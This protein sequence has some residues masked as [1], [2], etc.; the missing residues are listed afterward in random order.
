MS[1]VEKKP[2]V[3]VW[4]LETVPDL[5]AVARVHGL[6]KTE[7]GE[8]RKTL[9]NKFPRLLFHEI[10]CVGALVAE[11]KEGT[12]R[13]CRVETPHAG[14]RTE[15]ELIVG[16]GHLIE[17]FRPR[18]VSYNGSSFDMPVMRYRALI[19]RV[20]MPALARRAYFHRYGDAALDL[21][22]VLACYET[23]NKVSFHE[24]S[25]AL[26]L[27]G[28]PQGIDGKEVAGLIQDGRFEEVAAYCRSDVVGTFQIFLLHELF[29]G[30][31]EP[32][33]YAAAETDLDRFLSSETQSD[34]HPKPARRAAGHSQDGRS[35]AAG[36]HSGLLGHPVLQVGSA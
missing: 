13:I 10:V 9:G 35:R 31:L 18:L 2:C 17:Q 15:A 21:C 28:K 34:D 24:L 25:R 36:L 5:D 27:P 4:D 6:E 29:R 11:W 12:W 26:D 20:Q 1:E 16:F 33:S 23:R 22:D 19:N 14:E 8:I 7:E 30:S 3:L 32:D